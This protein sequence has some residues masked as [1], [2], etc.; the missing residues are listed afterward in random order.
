MPKKNFLN[1]GIFS[2]WQ[3]ATSQANNANYVVNSADR[4]AYLADAAG[5]TVTRVAASDGSYEYATRIGRGASAATINFGVRQALDTPASRALAAAFKANSGSG[6]L[7]IRYKKG[8]NWTGGEPLISIYA[9]TGTNESVATM[10]AWTGATE[11]TGGFSKLYDAGLN[12]WIS[13]SFSTGTSFDG[14]TQFGI[15]IA[16][17]C[18]GASTGADDYLYL[19]HIALVADSSSTEAIWPYEEPTALRAECER[20]YRNLIAWVPASTSR[21]TFPINMRDTPTIT[22][23]G[24]GF[25]STGTT[26][27]DLVCYQ[28][29]A[30]QQTLVLN[31]EL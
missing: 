24:A 4:W 13:T 5:G 23:G 12:T 20:Y 10:S 29:A 14:Y 27:E 3:R 1:N 18:T 19:D 28:T 16:W 25:T 8:A 11:L 22:G 31:A 6:R 15:Q 21:Y 30:A 9:G 7:A 2:L 26:A 17:Q